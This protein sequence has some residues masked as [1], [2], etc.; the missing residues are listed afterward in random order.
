[1]AVVDTRKYYDRRT[2]FPPGKFCEALSFMPFVTR[3]A[4][5]ATHV[6]AFVH[7]RESSALGALV[8][9]SANKTLIDEPRRTATT[10]AL[11]MVARGRL[12]VRFCL[13]LIIFVM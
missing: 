12:I 8:S 7:H 3:G 1:M 11:R 10:F 2:D 6:E 9:C 5:H 4:Y 13:F